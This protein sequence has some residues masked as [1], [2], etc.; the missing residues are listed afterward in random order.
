M[1]N[2]PT[3]AARV[4]AALGPGITDLAGPL[5]QT[6]ITALVARMEATDAQLQPDRSRPSPPLWDL[7]TTETPHWLGQTAG[8][9]VPS[10][11]TADQAR[12]YV[13]GRG[14][15]QRGRPAALRAAV[16]AT[17]T[18]TAVVR[19]TERVGGDAYAVRVTTFSAQ[20]PDAARTLAAALTEKPQG[21]LLTHVVAPG[22]TWGDVKASGRTFAQL[23]TQTVKQV[24]EAVPAA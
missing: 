15:S 22:Q 12:A 20:T 1:S 3:T 5:L 2:V 6:L 16:A 4:A 11:L 8:L 10:T 9:A 7:T 18:G 17:L 14:V 19:I 23:K 24:R 21:L 13:A